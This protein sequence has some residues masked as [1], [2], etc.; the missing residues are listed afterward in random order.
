MA[1]LVVVVETTQLPL[2]VLAEPQQ[3]DK[4]LL[5]VLV[6]TLPLIMARVVVEVLEA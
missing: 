2:Q 4:V 5:V 6:H 3:L 1:A